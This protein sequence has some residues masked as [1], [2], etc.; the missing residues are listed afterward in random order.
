VRSRGVT[1]IEILTVA[2]IIA[3]LVGILIPAT[4]MARRAALN[5]KQKMQFAAIETA[6]V[7]FKNDYGDYPP[8][9]A[10]VAAGGR[11]FYCGAQKLAE[12]LVGRDMMGFDPNS[13]WS[14][15]DGAYKATTGRRDLYLDPDTANAYRLGAGPGVVG[16]FDQ[17]RLWNLAAASFVLC[18]AFP[19]YQI[20]YTEGT[21][22]RYVR[23]G[24]PILYFRANRLGRTSQE[25]Y[26]FEDNMQIILAK[27]NIDVL[28]HGRSR[29]SPWG[30]DAKDRV[31]AFYAFIRDPRV[32]VVDLIN[33]P[34]EGRP[35]R[36]DSYILISAGYDSIYGTSDDVTNF[37]RIGGP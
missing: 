26:N 13:G 31:A 7:A 19:Q 8:S 11:D 34:G 15:D 29:M 25:I 6:L 4:Q 32:P 30:Q 2:A 37:A 5:G 12:A 35:Y 22:T 3:I 17:N 20:V 27:E 9:D 24:S 10:S 16:L 1:L 28:N 36:S 18:D 33:K 21:S 23:V 14:M